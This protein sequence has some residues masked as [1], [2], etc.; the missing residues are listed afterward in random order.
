MNS[1]EAVESESADDREDSRDPSTAQDDTVGGNVDMAGAR[2]VWDLCG[3]AGRRH[4]RTA[5]RSN[6]EHSQGVCWAAVRGRSNG[7]GWNHSVEM[8]NE[9]RFAAAG[10]ELAL[11]R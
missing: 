11:G 1:W 10:N 7:K 2:A 6:H 3:A 5:D 4:W 8:G 9:G